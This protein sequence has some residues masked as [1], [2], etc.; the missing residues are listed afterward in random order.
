MITLGRVAGHRGAT[1]EITVKVAA[2]DA[3]I[4]A[5][6]RRVLL[7]TAD[8]AM[9]EYA[10]ESSRAYRDRLVL[11]LCGVERADARP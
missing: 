4:W 11:K 1:G 8:G 2:G 7:E 5:G 6:L 3:A 10:I 9:D